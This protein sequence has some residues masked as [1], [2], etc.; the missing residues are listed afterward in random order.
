M[1]H[2]RCGLWG[3]SLSTLSYL[4]PGPIAFDPKSGMID[5]NKWAFLDPLPIQ[6]ALP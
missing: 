3:Y 6:N 1:L 4:H 2:S 5:A